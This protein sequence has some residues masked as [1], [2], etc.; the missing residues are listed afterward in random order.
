MMTLAQEIEK[1]KS[2]LL[3]ALN[4]RDMIGAL[5]RQERK[6]HASC[7]DDLKRATRARDVL[8][9]HNRYLEKRVKEL[10]ERVKELEV[11]P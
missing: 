3:W 1:I 10:E 2:N 9:S 11:R 8:T 4:E 6:A 7:K 5:L